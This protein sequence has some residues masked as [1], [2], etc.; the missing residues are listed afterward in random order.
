MKIVVCVKQVPEADKVA[1]DPET[2]TLIREIL[3]ECDNTED[4][5]K[6]IKKTPNKACANLF[7]ADPKQTIIIE[8]KATYNPYIWQITEP[9][10]RANH[11]LKHKN[12]K[13]QTQKKKNTE[14]LP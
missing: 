8:L 6:H 10:A 2:G 7:L 3:E 4:A 12:P 11:Y 14:P 1:V 5:I 9:D 13:P